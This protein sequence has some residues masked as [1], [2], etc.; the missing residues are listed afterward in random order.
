MAGRHPTS[1]VFGLVPATLVAQAAGT[2]E[3][4]YLDAARTAVA[5]T[6]TMVAVRATLGRIDE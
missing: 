5:S 3:S 1:E 6:S 4:G 2:S